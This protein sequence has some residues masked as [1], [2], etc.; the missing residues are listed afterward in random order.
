MLGNNSIASSESSEVATYLQAIAK[1]CENEYFAMPDDI[2]TGCAAIQCTLESDGNVSNLKILAHQHSKHGFSNTEF[3]D[4]TLKHT[5]LSSSPLP[6]PPQSLHYPLVLVLSI[7]ATGLH[8]MIF[9]VEPLSSWH[10][11]SAIE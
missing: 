5:V 7:K 6:K 11:S 2:Y 3:S 4:V 1:R 9:T 10:A 8:P